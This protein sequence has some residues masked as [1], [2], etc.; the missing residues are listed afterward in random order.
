MNII[1]ILNVFLYFSGKRTCVDKFTMTTVQR[2]SFS[3]LL[4]LFLSLRSSCLESISRSLTAELSP[5]I[6]Q[7]KYG[8]HYTYILNKTVSYI[9]QYNADMSKVRMK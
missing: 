9:F 7:A 8:E 2:L 4:I 1:L 5:I 6:V 3:C